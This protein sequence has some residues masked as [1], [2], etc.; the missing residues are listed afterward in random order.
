MARVVVVDYDPS[1]P[2][3]FDEVRAHVW[4]AVAD[5]ASRV[6]HVGSTAVPGLAAKPVIDIDVIVP[7]GL[8][9]EAIARLEGV[10]YEHEGDLG[11]TGREA[12][13]APSGLPRHHL[14][15]CPEGSL[16]LA[17]HIAVRDYL[18]RAPSDAQAYGELKKRLAVEFADDRDGYGRGKTEFILRVLQETGFATE[19]LSDIHRQNQ[20]PTFE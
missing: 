3:L 12:F 8:V 20:G 9:P 2:G 16:A 4:P 15:L 1:W 10:G 19:S 11:V 17:N 18:R 5:V 13:R 7:A 14:Y 6:E